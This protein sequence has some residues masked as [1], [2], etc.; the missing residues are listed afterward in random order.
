M[1]LSI[2]HA[3]TVLRNLEIPLAPTVRI[4]GVANG[5]V[6]GAVLGGARFFLGGRAV[7]V[8]QSGA[9]R[10]P[11]TPL[12]TNVVSVSVPEGMRFVA[13]RRGRKYYPVESSDAANLSP[14][15]RIYFRTAEEA[16]D[17]G[18]VR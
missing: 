14:L 18:Y 3:P 12:L 13:S 8:D 2:P 9:F 16:E 17:A 5:E 1:E 7:P 6:H 11:A 10:V 15:N 4:D